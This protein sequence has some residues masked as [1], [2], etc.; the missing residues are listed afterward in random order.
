[1]ELESVRRDMNERIDQIADS[2]TRRT[3][4]VMRTERE[5]QKAESTKARLDQQLQRELQRYDSA[6][7]ESIRAVDREIA[8]LE[9]RQRSL[10]QLQEMP[11][12]INELEEGAGASQGRID[13]LRSGIDEERRR[14]RFADENARAIGEQFKNIMLNVGSSELETDSCSCRS[15]MGFLGYRQ[16]R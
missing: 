5:L 16:R 15:G 4:A 1:M 13:R 10:I 11:R 7:V 3:R 14:L 12:A 6:Y 8:T 2:I 9:E